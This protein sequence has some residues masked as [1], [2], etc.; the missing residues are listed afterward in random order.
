MT[1]VQER[2]GTG[3]SKWIENCLVP[4]MYSLLVQ[5]FSVFWEDT[6]SEMFF[7]LF[8]ILAVRTSLISPFETGKP[9]SPWQSLSPFTQNCLHGIF[10]IF[11]VISILLVYVFTVSSYS[12]SWYKLHR[13]GYLSVYSLLNFVCPLPTI[14]P[15]RGQHISGTP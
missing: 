4:E 5:V 13:A 1:S 9:L 14:L 6:S 10:N 3:G 15:N 8:D 11:D 12:H 7:Q 2:I